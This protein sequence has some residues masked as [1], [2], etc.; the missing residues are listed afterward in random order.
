MHY[1]N[2]IIITIINIIKVPCGWQ[3]G[4]RS[5]ALCRGPAKHAVSQ[6]LDSSAASVFS[7]HK[8][9]QL[10]FSHTLP[11]LR[12][13]IE[14]ANLPALLQHNQTS[15]FP[16][17]NVKETNAVTHCCQKCIC[18]NNNNQIYKAPKALALEALVAGQLWVLIKSFTEEVRFKP[19]FKYRQWV[20]QRWLLS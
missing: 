11:L 1:R 2:V 4:W 10:H 5:L 12:Y 20:S 6:S 15:T 13:N 18:N 17:N 14:S 19:R 16:N 9:S 8:Q 3:N 7:L